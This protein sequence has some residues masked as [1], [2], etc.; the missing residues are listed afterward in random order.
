MEYYILYIYKYTYIHG[1]AQTHI[2]TDRQEHR[3]IHRH[4]YTKKRTKK[5]KMLRNDERINR[6]NAICKSLNHAVHAIF[7]FLLFLFASEI[8]T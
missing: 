5:K 3:N 6:I 7:E 1:H 2:V 4:A 8:S